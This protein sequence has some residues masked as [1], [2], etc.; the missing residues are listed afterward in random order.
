MWVRACLP[1][2]FFIIYFSSLRAQAISYQCCGEFR[3]GG[4]STFKWTGGGC[5]WGLK[6]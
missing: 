1:A 2:F 4:H 5:R 3:G 6:T